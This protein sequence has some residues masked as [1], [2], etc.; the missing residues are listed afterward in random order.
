MSMLRQKTYHAKPQRKQAP[1]APKRPPPEVIEQDDDEDE[2]EK[3][4]TIAFMNMAIKPIDANKQEQLA[5]EEEML[6]LLMEL[7]MLA[8]MLLLL[9]G[10]WV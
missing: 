6:S 1:P 3:S 5:R 2:A 4:A 8:N 9:D 7:N 10:M